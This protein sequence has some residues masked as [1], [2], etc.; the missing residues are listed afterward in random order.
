MSKMRLLVSA[1]CAAALLW[2]VP[3]CDKSSAAPARVVGSVSKKGQP[4]K[5]GTVSFHVTG[6]GV[7]TGNIKD[8]G[9]YVVTDLPVG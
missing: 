8:D 2:L 3:G 6:A 5:A 1:G 9:T 4:L 7:Y